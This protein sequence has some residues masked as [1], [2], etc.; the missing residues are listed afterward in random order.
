MRSSCK[1]FNSEQQQQINRYVQEKDDEF[2]RL[3]KDENEIGSVDNNKHLFHMGSQTPYG[4]LGVTP[5]SSI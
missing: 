2:E 5:R 4:N 3:L 1:E